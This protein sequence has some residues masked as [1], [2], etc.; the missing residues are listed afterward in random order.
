M[1][2]CDVRSLVVSLD[3]LSSQLKFRAIQIEVLKCTQEIRYLHHE[4][5][6]WSSLECASD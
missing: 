6:L 3:V 2:R 1:Y 5:S 4:S